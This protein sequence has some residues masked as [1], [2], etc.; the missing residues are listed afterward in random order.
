MRHHAWRRRNQI[1]LH[2][3]MIE[4]FHVLLL[5]RRSF[6]SYRMICDVLRLVDL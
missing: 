2:V 1:A 5:R 4:P 3:V 6:G